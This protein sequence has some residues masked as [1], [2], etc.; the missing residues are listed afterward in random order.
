MKVQQSLRTNNRVLKTDEEVNRYR[1]PK[2]KSALSQSRRIFAKTELTS[3]RAMSVTT[4]ILCIPSA[5]RSV[6]QQRARRSL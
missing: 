4:G 5:T 2:K 6:N 3:L 1:D